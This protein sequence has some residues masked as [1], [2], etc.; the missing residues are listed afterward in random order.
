MFDGNAPQYIVFFKVVLIYYV[1][2]ICEYLGA[3]YFSAHLH[4]YYAVNAFRREN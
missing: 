1:S 2:G 4:I 3:K